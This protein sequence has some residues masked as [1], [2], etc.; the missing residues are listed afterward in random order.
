MTYHFYFFAGRFP[1]LFNFS[2]SMEKGYLVELLKYIKRKRVFCL[3]E[4]ST[5]I[6]SPKLLYF[7]CLRE[8]YVHAKNQDR[9]LSKISNEKQMFSADFTS[10]SRDFTQHFTSGVLILIHS[11]DASILNQ[12]VVTEPQ[13][14]K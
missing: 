3:T 1:K 6:I 4:S 11:A 13:Y 14:F 5:E 9:S 7:K 2:D 12:A 10:G 8:W